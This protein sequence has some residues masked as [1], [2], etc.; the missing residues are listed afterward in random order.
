MRRNVELEARLID[1]LL[2]LTRITQGKL[3]LHRAHVPINQVID[4]AINTCELDLKAKGLT[5]VRT[6]IAEVMKE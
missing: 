4:D 6:T 1:D 5:L 3:A 2:D